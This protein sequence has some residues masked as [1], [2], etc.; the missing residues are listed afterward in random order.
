LGGSFDGATGQRPEHF[1][2][3]PAYRASGIAKY[4]NTVSRFQA[5]FAGT[6]SDAS[7][8]SVATRDQAYAPPNLLVCLVRQIRQGHAKRPIH[9][10]SACSIQFAAIQ[11]GTRTQIF[12][13]AI[14]E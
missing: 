9:Q 13:Q 2:L 6:A 5:H 4:P 8:M 1:P 12:D 3:A 14:Q 10:K 11:E 7:D